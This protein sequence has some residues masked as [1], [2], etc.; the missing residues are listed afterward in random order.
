MQQFPSVHIEA[1]GLL[2]FSIDDVTKAFASCSGEKFVH[3]ICFLNFDSFLGELAGSPAPPEQNEHLALT[4]YSNIRKYPTGAS[5]V[6]AVN[7][8]VF[9]HLL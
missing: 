7:D 5:Y 1:V 4:I 8:I 6:Y 3:W 2:F 9:A